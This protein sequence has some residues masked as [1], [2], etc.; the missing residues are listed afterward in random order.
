MS[1]AQSSFHELS[2][3]QSLNFL[4]KIFQRN[5]TVQQQHQQQQSQSDLCFAPI[6]RDKN[7]FSE[8][9]YNGLMQ[10]MQSK[11]KLHFGSQ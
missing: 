1:F 8:L 5:I 2:R 9:L 4:F 3:L 11:K 6:G 10:Q 7:R